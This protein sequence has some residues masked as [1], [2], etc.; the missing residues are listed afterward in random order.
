MPDGHLLSVNRAGHD[1]GAF[2]RRQMGNDL[3]PEEIEIDPGFGRPALA[4]PQQ[5][6]IK[7]PG[8]GQVIDRKGE[9]ESR[10]GHWQVPF[11][12]GFADCSS[13]HQ[14]DAPAMQRP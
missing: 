3:M 1:A 11:R 4:T 13:L 7:L 10:T 6:T 14:T 12:S 9:V 5:S 2:F 8:L